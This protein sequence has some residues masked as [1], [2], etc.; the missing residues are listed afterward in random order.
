MSQQSILLVDSTQVRR[1]AGLTG[2]IVRFDVGRCSL[3]TILVAATDRGV[4]A[5]SL[6]ENADLLL[7]ELQANFTPTERASNDPG[8]GAWMA[9][10]IQCV[11]HPW[12]DCPVPLDL[13]GTPF[14]QR[15]WQLLRE[16]PAGTTTTYTELAHRLGKPNG[17]RAVGSACAANQVAVVI[18]CHRVVRRDGDL[19]GY[20]WGI[21]RKRRLLQREREPR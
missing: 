13:Q 3:G 12:E 11:E 5:V 1:H 9:A 21:E 16:I 15:V 4:C 7:R 20:R 18:P 2:G 19:A 17:V 8:F 14:Q 10:I 6:G